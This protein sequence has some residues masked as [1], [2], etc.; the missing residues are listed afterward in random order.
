M[1]MLTFLIS[2]SLSD[3]VFE[4]IVGVQNQDRIVRDIDS[5]WF[6]SYP[7]YSLYVLACSF[8]SISVTEGGVAIRFHSPDSANW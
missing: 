7:E 1:M 5:G 4:R 8:V 3:P 2:F 6:S